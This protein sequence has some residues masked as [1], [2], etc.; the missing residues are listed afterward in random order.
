MAEQAELIIDTRNLADVENRLAE[1]GVWEKGAPV[2]ADERLKLARIGGLGNLPEYAQ[3]ARR[4]HLNEIDTL[5]RRTDRLFTDLDVL[6]YDLRAWFATETGSVPMLGKNRDTFIGYPQHKYYGDP[7]PLTAPKN[8][9]PAGSGEGGIRV[10]VVDTPLY[11]HHQFAKELVETDEQSTPD[12][13][14]NFAAWQGHATF[15][16]GK[17]QEVAPDAH[18]VVKAGL[19]GRTGRKTVWDTAKKIADFTEE[20]RIQVLNLSFGATTEDASPPLALRR[21]IDSVRRANPKLVIIAAAGNRG[22]APNPPLAIWPAAMTEVEAV[23][24]RNASFSMDR[25]WVDMA[26]DGVDVAGLYL[27]GTV[28]LAGEPI[29]F[30]GHAVL[31]G[32]SFAAARV[33]GAVAAQLKAYPG[34]PA[35][36]LRKVLTGPFATPFPPR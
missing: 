21:A 6:L 3:Q 17:I 30:T 32:T 26:A 34:D 23:G 31:S 18:V 12:D 4:A 19:D 1:L 15:V 27:D 35:R 24:A 9:P 2:D 28:M 22:S 25:Q 16:V 8:L 14:G 29:E 33:S 10:G 5:E 7:V 13:H 20:P 11:W 36:A